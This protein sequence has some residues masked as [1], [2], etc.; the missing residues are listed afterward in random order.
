MSNDSSQKKYINLSKIGKN[1]F[2]KVVEDSKFLR[3]TL[4]KSSDF[5]G[6]TMTQVPISRSD[7][8]MAIVGIIKANK[9]ECHVS[10]IRFPK[11]QFST[12][13]A[14][15]WLAENFSINNN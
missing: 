4:R 5:H 14:Q 6:D 8:I 13:K 10:A 15:K 12:E 9:A 2:R 7:G 1:G 11:S 3:I